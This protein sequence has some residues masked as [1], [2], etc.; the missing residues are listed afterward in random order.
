MSIKLIASD[1]DATLL[2]NGGSISP[3][4]RAAVIA[5]GERG[6]NFT[7]ATGR[8]YV[9]ARRIVEELGQRSGYMIVANGGAVV[10]LD[11]EPVMEW[12][13]PDADAEKVYAI[14]R[15]Y[16]IELLA[17]TRDA[18]YWLNMADPTAGRDE[19]REALGGRYRFV[20]GDMDAFERKGLHSPYKLA[21]DC[22]DIDQLEKLRAELTEA[23]LAVSSSH[24]TNLEIMSRGMGKGAA[25]SWLASALGLARDEVMTFGDN[26]NDLDLL[27]AAGWPV[28][29]GNAVPELKAA[30]RIIAPRD[31][32]DGVAR[33]IE[34][35]L[36][37][38]IG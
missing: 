36:R 4:T 15:K 29:M 26:T 17:Y 9:S 1:V 7:I 37:G 20:A 31:V 23:G 22:D 24:S 10:D 19:S 11:G 8:W 32:E 14:A 38:E 34:K 21:V 5:C 30:A 35:V 12:G 2:P 3:R 28:A 27:Q 25:V 33:T 6:V 16:P 13:L 18:L